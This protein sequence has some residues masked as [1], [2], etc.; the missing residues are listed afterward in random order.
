VRGV[1]PTE[2]ERYFRLQAKTASGRTVLLE[3]T[4]VPYDIDG[5]TVEVLGLAELGHSE[6]VY[7]DC[8]VE[9]QDNQI[10]I[11][12]SGDERAVRRISAVE[13][14]SVAPYSPFYNPGGPGNNPTPGV[15]YSAPSPP[16]TQPILVALDDPLTVTFIDLRS[17][18]PLGAT[19]SRVLAALLE[20][21]LPGL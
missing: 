8:Y 20:G 21:R 3:K 17:R 18:G 4:G 2:Y 7:D 1:Y 5:G 15:R 19:P 16:H 14:P 10:D 9:D 12:L 6:P 11:I 13:V